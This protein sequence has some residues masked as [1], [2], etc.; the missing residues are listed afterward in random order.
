MTGG[1]G[2]L[3]ALE[4]SR[5]DPSVLFAGSTRGIVHRTVNRGDTWT[6][7]SSGLPIRPVND[8]AADP[9]DTDRA[10]AV[11]GGFNTAHLWEWTA[12]GGWTP[13]GD[14][15]PNVPA[16]TVLMLTNADVLVGTD[17]GVFISHDGGTTFEPYMSGLPEGLVV[18][19]LKYDEAEK[20]VTAGT[21]GRGAWQ[22]AIGPALALV[23]FDSIVLPLTED[24]GDGDANVEPGE[25]W[26]VRV[27]LRNGGGQSANGVVARLATASPAVTLLGPTTR[28]FGD[29][30][31]GAV[32][33]PAEPFTFL[34]DPAAACGQTVSFD[35]VDI[36]SAIPAASHAAALGAF[37]VTIVDHNLPSTMTPQ[38]EEDFDPQ[39]ASGFSHAA[40]APT[41]AGCA[42]SS[43]I[44]QWRF[45]TK[46]AA[47]GESYH[48]GRGPGNRYGRQLFAWLYVG[49]RDSIEGP[50]IVLPADITAAELSFAHWYETTVGRAG[51]QVLI[52]AVEDDQD[53]YVTLEPSGGYSPGV[54]GGVCNALSGLEAFHGSSNG[55][56]EASFDL[57]PYLG[58]RVYLAFVFGS[59]N[60][61]GGG[62]GWYVDDLS[63]RTW[64]GG[65]PVCD[66]AGWPG[67]VPPAM[68]FNLV[69][70]DTIEAVWGDSCNAD[71]VPGQ[72]YAILAGDLDLLSLD[73][74]YSHAPVDGRCD[75]VSP[76]TFTPGPANEYFLVVPHLDG[77][78][79]GAGADS[80]GMPRPVGSACGL[81]REATCD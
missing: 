49:G 8:I 14:V 54:L 1:V 25:T 24:D 69:A 70:P 44:D 12:S 76:A 37:S 40:V 6:D 32:G 10:L 55:W 41:I 56:V 38:L 80:S 65:E 67:T 35:V 47:H 23:A 72:T 73:G 66:T 45:A 75:L 51:G 3:I 13:R 58:R 16:N 64:T 59:A 20:L 78:V 46:D 18:M 17:T 43:F 50:G 22:V 5:N 68:V 9:T 52:D 77:R 60:E 57:L 48:C 61:T 26:S 42:S 63:V 11:L 2:Q 71:E 28:S 27:Q 79:G 15:L 29:L 21:F 62:E 53:V 81:A 36:T 7:I 31:P 19:D 39:P 74:G 30:G 34:V 33:E 4:L